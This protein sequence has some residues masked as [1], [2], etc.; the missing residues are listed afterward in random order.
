M[1]DKSRRCAALK[2]FT[3]PVP[4]KIK[5]PCITRS[6]GF[7]ATPRTA[8]VTTMIQKH[9]LITKLP[10]FSRLQSEMLKNLFRVIFIGS[11]TFGGRKTTFFRAFSAAL[12]LVIKIFRETSKSRNRNNHPGYRAQP[13]N[14][15]MKPEHN[16]HTSTLL[17]QHPKH[18]NLDPSGLC[19]SLWPPA[20]LNGKSPNSQLQ[21]GVL[22]MRYSTGSCHA[23][24]KN[25]QGF[26]CTRNPSLRDDKVGN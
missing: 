17:L 23:Q 2:S 8:L 16:S 15:G 4:S 12:L 14:P 21:T 19:S 11:V 13:D 5:A 7:R 10:S 1:T 26:V 20:A 6:S 9:A 25:I 24:K 22:L 18:S 3:F